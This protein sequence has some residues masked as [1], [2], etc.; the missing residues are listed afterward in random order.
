M[1]IIFP[2]LRFRFPSRLRNGKVENYCEIWSLIS[3]DSLVKLFYQFPYVPTVI[4]QN[5]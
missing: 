3:S 1:K 5:Y 4:F 2:G